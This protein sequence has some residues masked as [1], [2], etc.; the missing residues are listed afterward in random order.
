MKNTFLYIFAVA[1][2]P[3]IVG[4]DKD[5]PEND[6]SSDAY[7]NTWIYDNM[8]TYY[9][10]KDHIPSATDKTLAPDAYFASLLYKPDDRF[11]W[12]QEN[13]T[14][15]LN[16][17]SGVQK[18]AGYDFSLYYKDAQHADIVGAITYVK[19]NSPASQQGLRRGDIFIAIN[20]T[21]I[22]ADNYRS[23]TGKMSE[24]HTLGLATHPD[25]DSVTQTITLSVVEYKENPIFLDTTYDIGGTKIGYFVYNF[26]ARDN[27][28]VSLAY[29]KELNTLFGKFKTAGINDLIID[30]RYNGG[31]AVTTSIALSSM[32]ANQN[33]SDIFGIAQYN[34]IL[35]SEYRKKYGSDYDK[36]YF[37]D[38]IA[39]TTIS[40]NKLGMSRLY[41]IATGGTASASELVING[42]R[43]YMPVFI[44]GDTTYGKNVGSYSLYEQN[45][46]R[47][48]WGMQ[49]IVVKFANKNGESDYGNGFA[50]NVVVSERD[51]G[52]PFKQLGDI[53]ETMLQATL[54]HLLGR[55]PASHSMAKSYD[56]RLNTKPIWSSTDRYPAR[57]NMYVEMP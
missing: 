9:L 7:V 25:W 5:D 2:L 45:S 54:D 12:I 20:G 28:D 11:S 18:E 24:A 26:F 19:P 32:I 33:V 50:P 6:S 1:L 42:L 46:T 15:L 41:V 14:D 4:C 35:T 37:V 36:D 3:A 23:L 22:T 21:K 17:L 38:K 40:I 27:G 49:P 53:E 10:W 30:L 39:N 52:F 57:K 44:V 56:N 16:M 34:D 8:K 31:G 13:Y 48:K 55:S 29:E 43:P 51:G 47:N